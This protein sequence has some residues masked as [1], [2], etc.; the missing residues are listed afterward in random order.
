MSCV[1]PETRSTF[2]F[3]AYKFIIIINI[4][5]YFKTLS[6]FIKLSQL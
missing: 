3:K 1:S 4:I 5:V 6:N 2:C